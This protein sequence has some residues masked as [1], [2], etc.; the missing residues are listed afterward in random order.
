MRAFTLLVSA[1]AATVSA[2]TSYTPIQTY[3]GG[4]LMT[5]SWD[6]ARTAIKVE[7]EDVKQYS[8]FRLYWN[9]NSNLGYT[10]GKFDNAELDTFAADGTAVNDM[11]NK[12]ANPNDR[13]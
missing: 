1:L 8:K 7:M 10:Q 5:I 6:T 2:V 13:Y 4:P 11:Y 9:S 3:N 12:T